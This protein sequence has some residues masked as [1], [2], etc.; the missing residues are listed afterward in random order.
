MTDRAYKVYAIEN[1]TVIDH[2]PTPMALKVVEIL[3]IGNEGIF[4]IGV[5]FISKKHPCG[6]D[7]V[8]IENRILLESETD[9]IALIAP[10]ATINISRDGR[11]SEKRK[12]S[13]PHTIHGVMECPNPN[14]ATNKLGASRH[15]SL[16]NKAEMSYRCSYCERVTQVRPENLTAPG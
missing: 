12:I 13:I 1:G 5:G 4:T 8:K 14:C 11:V 7:I 16:E 2:I 3:G 6:K 10:D 15:F 9:T